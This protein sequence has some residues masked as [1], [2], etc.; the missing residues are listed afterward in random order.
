[1][2]EPD[3]IVDGVAIHLAQKTDAGKLVVAPLDVNALQMLVVAPGAEG[4]GPM[5]R[6][7]DG[8]ARA[9]LDALARH[10]GG[11]GDFSTL[12][13]DYLAE[14]ARVDRLLAYLTGRGA[15]D[16]LMPTGTWV[17]GVGLRMHDAHTA[18]GMEE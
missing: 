13:A 7:E 17:P 4:P 16:G 10:Y 2:V 18:E 8:A 11:T 12:R 9:L 6:L 15:A 3:F 1:M 14:R 5:L